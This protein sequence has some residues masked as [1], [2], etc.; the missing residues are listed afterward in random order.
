MRRPAGGPDHEPTDV[1]RE[2]VK[3]ASGMGLTHDQI[4]KL[5]RIS[6][7][8][9]RKYYARELEVG[10][11][12]IN[13]AVAMNL[14]RIATTGDDKTAA[15]VCLWWLERRG[16]AAWKKP[17]A[18]VEMTVREAPQVIDCSKLTYEQRQ[19]FKAICLK[20]A[21]PKE[22]QSPEEAINEAEAQQ[23]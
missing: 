13:T 9:L 12:E 7:V 15:S 19:Q 6:D 23:G 16:G 11:T 22:L 1:L 5:F 14:F 20:L 2:Q 18:K 17:D 8:T 21:A 4:C 10:L 3:T